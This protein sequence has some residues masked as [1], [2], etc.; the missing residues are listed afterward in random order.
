MKAIRNKL[1]NVVHLFYF[2]ITNFT[3][4]WNKFGLLVKTFREHS[5]LLNEQ[6][7]PIQVHLWSSK[8]APCIWNNEILVPCWTGQAGADENFR[9]WIKEILVCW[10]HWNFLKFSYLFSYILVFGHFSYILEQISSSKWTCQK[11]K[12]WTW[13]NLSWAKA[14]NQSPSYRNSNI[15]LSQ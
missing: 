2:W 12:V 5:F 13:H 8:A 9:F 10:Y 15:M 6:R 4:S 14:Q 3:F 7:D 11:S 1:L